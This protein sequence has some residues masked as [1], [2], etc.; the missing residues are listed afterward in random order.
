VEP[1]DAVDVA[2]EIG[3]PVVVKAV[4]AQ[5]VHKT[6]VGAVRLGLKDADEV[7]RA[8]KELGVFSGRVL[9]E[10][11]VTGAVAELIVGVRAEPGFG[12]A[13]TIG[14][15]G[16]L[17]ELVRDT[18]TLLLP[19]DRHQVRSAL[20]DLRVARLLTGFRGAPPAD[21]DA[22]VEAVLAV[23]RYATE[24]GA[25][26]VAVNPLLVFPDGVVAV[27]AVIS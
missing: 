22:A 4:S 5:L 25:R 12:L 14:S 10:R 6:E 2:A 19:V 23:T 11:M 7:R 9:V 15:G 3:Y 26:D 13:L 21:I 18:A 1:D 20:L 17:V 16:V 27:D 8:A 24:R